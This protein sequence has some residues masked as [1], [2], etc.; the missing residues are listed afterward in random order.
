MKWLPVFIAS[1]FLVAACDD[2]QED[3]SN[4]PLALEVNRISG[5]SI[6]LNWNTVQNA[7]GYE[8]WRSTYKDFTIQ[9][10]VRI[11]TVG[12]SVAEYTDNELPFSDSLYYSVSIVQSGQSK[13]SNTV[14]VFGNPI[15][16]ILPYQMKLLPEKNHAFVRG[17]SDVIL[18]DYEQKRI[19]VRK[20]FQA[21]VGAID[22]ATYNGKKEV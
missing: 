14:P 21:K 2:K 6:E 13:K 12:Q 19:L 8:I 17:Y 11:A 3:L 9:D 1:W 4:E 16:Y 15:L 20:D 5:Y 22:M 18:L 10:P 7:G